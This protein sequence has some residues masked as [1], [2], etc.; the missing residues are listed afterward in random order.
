MARRLLAYLRGNLPVAMTI[1]LLAAAIIA[2]AAYRAWRLSRPEGADGSTALVVTGGDPES[3]GHASG[4]EGLVDALR[5][6]VWS[7][8]DGLCVLTFGGGSFSE[9]RGGS[10]TE[11]EYRVTAARIT[12]TAAKGGTLRVTTFAV[13]TPSGPGIGTLTQ[14]MVGGEVE[15]ARVECGA[16]SRAGEYLLVSPAIT[17]DVDGPGEVW[18]SSRGTTLEGLGEAVSEWCA[19]NCPTARSA[20]WDRMERVRHDD[21]AVDITL[22]LDNPASTR[23]TVTVDLTTGEVSVRQ[24]GWR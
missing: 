21:G 3:W 22:T 1:A 6:G 4:S 11:T 7:T 17:I 18:C 5:A 9:R 24:G 20:T 2:G 10:S 8:S 16:F 14:V 19:L 23:V 12:T 13:E 15:S